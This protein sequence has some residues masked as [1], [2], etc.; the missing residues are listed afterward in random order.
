MVSNNNFQPY[1]YIDITTFHFKCLTLYE[2]LIYKP[3]L[4]GSGD[5]TL[6]LVFLGFWTLFITLESTL[7]AM[8]QNL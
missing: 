6:Q 7:E 1:Y 5:T 3:I 4:K 2:I 8:F